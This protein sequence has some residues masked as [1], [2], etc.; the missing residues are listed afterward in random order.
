MG[1]GIRLKEPGVLV[2]VV[3]DAL[4]YCITLCAMDWEG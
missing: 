4:V 2:A 3:I 1:Q